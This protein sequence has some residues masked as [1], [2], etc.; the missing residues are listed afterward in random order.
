MYTGKGPNGLKHLGPPM[1]RVGKNRDFLK[2]KKSD[3][4][5]LNRIFLI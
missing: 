4:F 5:Y 1:Y 2:F 3:F